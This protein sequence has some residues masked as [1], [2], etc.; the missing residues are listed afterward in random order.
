MRGPSIISEHNSVKSVSA[1]NQLPPIYDYEAYIR[2]EIYFILSGFPFLHVFIFTN[3]K[4]KTL[5]FSPISGFVSS[6]LWNRNKPLIKKQRPFWSKIQVS[7]KLNYRILITENWL[8]KVTIQKRLLK[9][10]RILSLC[11]VIVS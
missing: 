7:Q 11:L 5:H 3:Q 9:F 10:Y 2:F 1:E 6:I 8:Q 4:I